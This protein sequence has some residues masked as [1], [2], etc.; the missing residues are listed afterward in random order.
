[1]DGQFWI[2]AKCSVKNHGRPTRPTH[3]LSPLL[4]T[5]TTTVRN[6]SNCIKVRDTFMEPPGEKFSL[7]AATV[8]I[9]D[10]MRAKA[11][12][13]FPMNIQYT[14]ICMRV[15]SYAVLSI[16]PGPNAPLGVTYEVSGGGT[17]Y[18]SDGRWWGGGGGGGGKE[19]AKGAR[20]RERDDDA[21]R[22]RYLRN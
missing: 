10:G 15:V 5:T 20:D 13:F 8:E 12:F 6:G 4:V 2:N 11:F 22:S 18:G 9:A 3:P 16:D 14:C 7:F 19:E 1:M 21:A 17:G